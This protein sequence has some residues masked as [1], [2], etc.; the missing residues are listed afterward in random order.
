[1]AGL[2]L[3][4]A[5]YI[6]TDGWQFE[7]LENARRYALTTRS[8]GQL[9][10][11]SRSPL[12]TVRDLGS[13]ALELRADYSKPVPIWLSGSS[14]TTTTTDTVRLQPTLRY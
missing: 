14:Q 2:E 1:M 9:V 10:S 11:E 12:L 4:F 6:T 7:G 13:G 3:L 8:V 5:N